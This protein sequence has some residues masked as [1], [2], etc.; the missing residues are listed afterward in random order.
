MGVMPLPP[1]II[2]TCSNWFANYVVERHI[3]ETATT[4]V[5]KVSLRTLVREL[6]NGTLD[7]QCLSRLQVVNI[8]AH[9]SLFVPL[10]QEGEFTFEVRRGNGGVRTNNGLALCID[11]R[12]SGLG[13]L[14]DD[15]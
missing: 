1:A 7:S 2:P 8:L 4:G 10:N 5:R 14:D 12:C 15:T 9:L 3:S 11:E 13:R 6:H